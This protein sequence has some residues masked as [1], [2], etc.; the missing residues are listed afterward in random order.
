M[1]EDGRNDLYNFYRRIRRKDLGVTHQN[2]L[3]FPEKRENFVHYDRVDGKVESVKSKK[4]EKPG[5]I[6]RS[7]SSEHEEMSKQTEV[8]RHCSNTNTKNIFP[9]E[10]HCSANSPYRDTLNK[11]FVSP[12]WLSPLGNKVTQDVPSTTLM[13]NSTATVMDVVSPYQRKT[14]KIAASL[15]ASLNDSTVSWTS[16][17]ATPS[18]FVLAGGEKQTSPQIAS[19]NHALNTEQYPQQKVM[20]HALFSSHSPCR[21]PSSGD[22]WS[23]TQ[24]IIRCHSPVPEINSE[25]ISCKGQSFKNYSNHPQMV[26]AHETQA[27]DMTSE[28]DKEKLTRKR[29]L[30]TIKP[31]ENAR[32]PLKD[33]NVYN[34][35]D[36]SVKGLKTA[37]NISCNLTDRVLDSSK[38]NE[39]KTPEVDS[40]VSIYKTSDL[41]YSDHNL[42][43]RVNVKTN[44]SSATLD[45]VT[46][47]AYDEVYKENPFDIIC[48]PVST[49]YEF[50]LSHLVNNNDLQSANDSFPKPEN[51]SDQRQ[52]DSESTNSDDIIQNKNANTVDKRHLVEGSGQNIDSYEISSLSDQSLNDVSTQTSASLSE[53]LQDLS[54]LEGN[55]KIISS[56]SA[57]E[58][59]DFTEHFSQRERGHITLRKNLVP[60]FKRVSETGNNFD[61]SS[62][63]LGPS[64]A[65]LTD[66]SKWQSCKLSLKRKKRLAEVFSY[67]VFS[68]EGYEKLN[69]CFK[70]NLSIEEDNN[71]LGL[72][73]LDNDI[74]INDNNDGLAPTHSVNNEHPVSPGK[75]S[76][77][78]KKQ[79]N[80]V[81]VSNIA[82]GKRPD[83]SE[84]TLT[85][86]DITRNHTFN[87]NSP[88]ALRDQKT[89]NICSKLLTSN[90]NFYNED[91]STTSLLQR[92]TLT[93]RFDDKE[94]FNHQ[95]G[96]TSMKDPKS[97]SE[98]LKAPHCMEGPEGCDTS[99]CHDKDICSPGAN[100][101]ECDDALKES[102]LKNKD[103]CH[104][105]QFWNDTFN[106][107]DFTDIEE[108]DSGPVEDTKIIMK[109]DLDT[110]CKADKNSH[111]SSSMFDFDGLTNEDKN[112]VQ[113]NVNIP[114]QAKKFHR[115]IQCGM[116]SEGFGKKLLDG[117]HCNKKSAIVPE[118]WEVEGKV[119]AA[120]I[121]CGFK[122]ARGNSVNISST[123]L[124]NAKKLWE[125]ESLKSDG[126][127]N[128]PS[129][130]IPTAPKR[131]DNVDS[132]SLGLMTAFESTFPRTKI[133]DQLK[134]QC[135]GNNNLPPIKF[136][137][138]NAAKSNQSEASECND[139]T[140]ISTIT[141]NQSACS[142]NTCLN[143]DKKLVL[144]SDNVTLRTDKKIPEAFSTYLSCDVESGEGDEK[145]SDSIIS[146]KTIKNTSD[147]D[148]PVKSELPSDYNL[149]P[150]MCPKDSTLK[151]NK[152][153][154]HECNTITNI[155]SKEQIQHSPKGNTD[156]NSDIKL[157]VHSDDVSLPT[158]GKVSPV[159]FSHFNCK[160]DCEKVPDLV[161]S[162]DNIEYTSVNNIPV[163]S[164]LLT[165]N[166]FQKQTLVDN[167]HVQPDNS[168][169]ESGKDTNGQNRVKFT[170][171]RGKDVHVSKVA[172]EKAKRIFNEDID[173]TNSDI[174]HQIY[175]HVNRRVSLNPE[176]T[177][178]QDEVTED[179]RG[180]VTSTTSMLCEKIPWEDANVTSEKLT[181]EEF[182]PL[183]ENVSSDIVQSASDNY[184]FTSGEPTFSRIEPGQISNIP[185]EKTANES[186]P[187]PLGSSIA[188]DVKTEESEKY[189]IPIRNLLKGGDSS[190]KLVK[191]NCQVRNVSSVHDKTL[192]D[193]VNCA[194]QSGLSPK[195]K[196]RET[197]NVANYE[198]LGGKIPLTVGFST[199]N[200]KSLEVSEKSLKFVKSILRDV[201]SDVEFINPLLQVPSRS[202]TEENSIGNRKRDLCFNEGGIENKN[203]KEASLLQYNEIQNLPSNSV[204]SKSLIKTS[205]GPNKQVLSGI[206]NEKDSVRNMDHVRNI[207]DTEIQLSFSVSE[208][209]DTSDCIYKADFEETDVEDVKER[210][211]SPI[212][213]SQVSNHK[214]KRVNFSCR[215]GT[216]QKI[217][218]YPHKVENNVASPR[219]IQCLNDIPHLSSSPLLHRGKIFEME[220]LKNYENEK[221]PKPVKLCGSGILITNLTN[222]NKKH[223]R[224]VV[225]DQTKVLQKYPEIGN[226]SLDT[227]E[228]ISMTEAFLRDDYLESEVSPG[229]KRPLDLDEVE[230]VSCKR[231]HLK[232]QFDISMN[233]ITTSIVDDSILSKRELLVR[234]QLMT[235]RCKEQQSVQPVQGLLHKGRLEKKKEERI[236][237]K[238]LGPLQREKA[239]RDSVIE[240]FYIWNVDLLSQ[241]IVAIH[242]QI[243]YYEVISDL[244][245]H[246]N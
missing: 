21:Q 55:L 23:P 62:K 11:S 78:T 239:I 221:S 83:L 161:F 79:Q 12:P 192:L 243:K 160:V 63:D 117:M 53:K 41:P 206:E 210:T 227:Q 215:K 131:L 223:F 33:M 135:P 89:L 40:V 24:S 195:I 81:S 96:H 70:K 124:L 162:S 157:L 129:N 191:P 180:L 193:H 208:H 35:D 85:N 25:L 7:N 167:V 212:I 106:Y 235:I 66:S 82:R 207:K 120:P 171:A 122:T 27:F 13:N 176:I 14:E 30:A 143:N 74:V 118:S 152:S 205:N 231:K 67:P 100:V 198:S 158:D 34:S 163:K 213:G 228:I 200:G 177:H 110:H 185:F 151:S 219:N 166:S 113:S 169:L 47:T 109:R 16:A 173:V 18:R 61:L 144:P 197:S 187:F 211:P 172:L 236:C 69:L 238:N 121:I 108:T 147:N 133:V 194:S 51:I 37:E 111:S 216:N 145:V 150:I 128:L 199:A 65:E 90:S 46:V 22:E 182:F 234:K 4:T 225:N 230:S 98:Y 57:V 58:S 105:T 44:I 72:S 153:T 156:I 36:V 127:S 136:P 26:C 165:M 20:G 50:T 99:H 59:K 190:A 107:F 201:D 32:L 224:A 138:N 73:I 140:N 246:Y 130:E 116:K 202:H 48:S 102:Q 88:S 60:L 139:I 132:S 52:Y 17:L 39:L 170:T 183:K 164:E 114:N 49:K 115:S 91:G 64:T 76:L 241:R 38:E 204:I 240:E 125:E 112:L 142:I 95:L 56:Q 94:N 87:F 229:K 101:P 189:Q 8:T 80:F 149:S 3:K 123:S 184:L 181:F 141:Q 148:I 77:I 1:E 97:S 134:N 5:L 137:I 245:D 71:K 178:F 186:Q 84:S 174:C 244:V 92:E 104:Y 220:T 154:A 188:K 29:C 45:N 222:E 93:T 6:L 9:Y 2:W 68:E 233:S 232:K 103:S 54:H 242:Y 196:W 203:Y 175:P 159:L 43:K 126:L 31:H 28:F 146:D 15:R 42:C 209:L 86:E 179:N 217:Q 226:P 237:L 155:S 218:E 19:E 119:V 75:S 214:R 10:P 168:I